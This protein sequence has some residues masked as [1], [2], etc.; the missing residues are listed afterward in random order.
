MTRPLSSVFL[1]A[2]VFLLVACA[3]RRTGQENALVPQVDRESLISNAERG[4]AQEQYNLG[5]QYERGMVMSQNFSEAVRWYR[6]AAIQ[7]DANGQFK[8]CEMSERGQG[9]PQDYQEALRW[10]ALAADQ[11]HARAMFMLGRLYH[12]AHGVPPD[13]V[14]A[15]MWYNLATANGYEQGKRWRDR[16]AEEMSPVQIA[17]AQKLAREWSLRMSLRNG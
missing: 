7:G 2:V 4:T 5:L 11:G 13:L 12:T 15:H 10:C 9:V 8:V 14:R 17:E 6:R 3:D 1:A 16:L